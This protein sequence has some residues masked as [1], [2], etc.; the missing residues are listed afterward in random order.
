[1]LVLTR[2]QGERICIGDD[3]EISV[4]AIRGSR[5]K[6]AFSAPKHISIKRQ[7]IVFAEEPLPEVHE[8]AVST[9]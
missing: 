7:E 3:I 8:Y 9:V 2:R 1:M 5:V 6:L 4:V